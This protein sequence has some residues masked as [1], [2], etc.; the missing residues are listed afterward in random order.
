[1]SIDS[2]IEYILDDIRTI[3]ENV[4][5]KLSYTAGLNETVDSK[6]EGDRYVSAML[7]RD[8]FESHS[9][10]ERDILIKAGIND[11]ELIE[12]CYYDK[13]KIPRSKRDLC[14]KYKREMII[15]EFYET[16]EYYRELIG[17]PPLDTPE[18]DFIYLTDEQVDYYKLEEVRPI[19]EYPTEIQTKLERIV[20]QELIEM[21]P[22][23]KYLTHLGSK[24]VDLVRAREAKNFEIIFADTTLDNVFLKSF[25][26]T[27]A[28]C[29]EYFMSVIYN[30]NFRDRY[31]LYENFIGMSIMIMAIQRMITNTIKMSIDR[32][33]YDLN[34]IKKMFDCYGV[35][36]FE[37]LPLDYQRSIIKHLNILIRTKSTDKCLYDISSI[38]MY[39]RISIYKYMLVKERN[40]DKEGNPVYVE[41]E[42]YDDD[43]NVS[44]V[45]DYD[46]IYDVY[47]QSAD[48]LETNMSLAI[49]SRPNR[50]SYLEITEDD[51][52]W[53]DTDELKKELYEREFNYIDTKYLGV[54]VMYNLTDLLY[55]TCYFLNM[56]VDNKDTT[57]PTRRQLLN[58][59]AMKT[60]TDYLFLTLERFSSIPVSIFDAVVVLCA[61]VAKKNGLKGNI[62][63]SDA[64]KILAVKGFNFEANFDL[65]RENIKKYPRIF[66]DQSI[67]KYLDLLDIKTVDDIETLYNNFKNFADF[68]VDRIAY[69]E[70]INEYHAYKQ[71]YKVFT[72]REETG[73]AFTM[74]NGKIANTYMEYLY[75]SVPHIAEIIEELH[76]D[77][78]GVYIEH[79]IGRLNELVPDIEYL[80]AMNG[81]NNNIV[82]A[83]VSLINFFKSYTTDLRNLNV[84]YVF[85]DLS[86]N[87]IRMVDDPRL[88]IK[89]YPRETAQEYNDLI[90]ATSVGYKH[91]EKID[92]DFL[93]RLL[94]RIQFKDKMEYDEAYYITTGFERRDLLY[95]PY[96]DTSKVDTVIRPDENTIKD[97]K[98]FNKEQL[99]IN[100]KII[101]D[102][103]LELLSEVTTTNIDDDLTTFSLINREKTRSASSMGTNTRI[104][105]NEKNDFSVEIN[106][107]EK[108]L[109]MRETIKIIYED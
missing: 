63:H 42:V 106:L 52:L 12:D 75:D 45:P 23:R 108:P 33:F 39:D 82:K 89:L 80:S 104:D 47:F 8:I 6:R 95:M 44:Y 54:N 103:D 67:V 64:S 96:A 86:T 28:F 84:I 30:R 36:F 53:W 56:L 57:S 62:I 18:E 27:Y 85:D 15:E 50:H 16:N 11:V 48:I 73:E 59:D 24:K 61:L 68:C 101:M 69:T 79:V 60:G 81:T 31:E 13:Y 41:K 14:L 74:T 9:Y 4:I 46:K 7:E 29:R 109:K 65:I 20:I 32:D 88:F 26:Q 71:L 40:L 35:P 107:K 92:I 1:M 55:E 58:S 2:Q 83:L 43:G 19:H 49:E 38:L 97:E 76:K 100:E 34:S 90:H 22:D 72:V 105:F 78:L 5:V 93:A 17:L 87:M 10:Y 94:N 102:D 99:T 21:Y 98:L 25:F 70:D 66:K 51:V 37:D 3:T 91:Y 77:K